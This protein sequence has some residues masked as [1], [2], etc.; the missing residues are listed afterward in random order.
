MASGEFEVSGGPAPNLLH[1]HIEATVM[2]HGGTT[3]TTIIRADQAWAVDLHWD[4]HGALVP[5]ISGMWVVHIYLESI[6]PGAELKLP[7]PAPE[8]KIPVN[9]ISGHYAHHFH[10]PAGRVPATHGST[11]YKL[12]AAITYETQYG[13]P[14]PMAGYVEGPILQFYNP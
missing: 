14:G 8:I 7:D 13:T 10:V 2:E 11:P 9:Q 6:G 12:V 4:L 5:M 3:P 1:G